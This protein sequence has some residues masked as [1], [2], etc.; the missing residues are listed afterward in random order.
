MDFARSMRDLENHQGQMPPHCPRDLSTR[1][2][3]DQRVNPLK[4]GFDQFSSNPQN[5]NGHPG[6]KPGD[7]LTNFDRQCLNHADDR[8]DDQV[9][10]VVDDLFLQRFH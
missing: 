9:D 1:L 6:Q 3:I 10:R 7:L 4:V 2:V 5:I 8:P